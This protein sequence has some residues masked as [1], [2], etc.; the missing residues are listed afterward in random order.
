MDPCRPKTEMVRLLIVG[1]VYVRVLDKT[2]EAIEEPAFNPRAPNRFKALIGCPDAINAGP[3]NFALN[4]LNMT[5]HFVG[6][7]Y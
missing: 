1:E 6:N 5:G 2:Y 4:P 3:T 7:S